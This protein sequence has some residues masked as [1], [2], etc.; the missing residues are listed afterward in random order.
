MNKKLSELNITLRGACIITR[1]L[2]G[3]FYLHFLLFFMWIGLNSKMF[4]NVQVQLF[5]L[6]S[7]V[8]EAHSV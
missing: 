5:G 8:A 2:S 7:H 6:H 3:R 4:E 1:S